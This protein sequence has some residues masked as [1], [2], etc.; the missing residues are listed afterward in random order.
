[1]YIYNCSERNMT[2]YVSEFSDLTCIL[3]SEI[4]TIISPIKMHGAVP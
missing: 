3:E 4:I 1:M 2:F